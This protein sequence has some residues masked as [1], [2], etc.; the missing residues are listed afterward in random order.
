MNRSVELLDRLVGV[1]VET[2][3]GSAL[4]EDDATDRARELETPTA[5]D[6]GESSRAGGVIPSSV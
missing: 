4:V 2:R 6:G 1:G 3:K 5:G